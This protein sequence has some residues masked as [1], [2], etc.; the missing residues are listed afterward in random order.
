MASGSV[1]LYCNL[2]GHLWRRLDPELD[3][4]SLILAS[5]AAG[6]KP[7]EE[8]RPPNGIPRASR[9][10]VR[11]PMRYRT[12]GDL[13]WRN[14]VTENISRSGILF[15]P[16]RAIEPKMPVDMILVLPGVVAGEPPSRLRCQG[17]IV[18]TEV[19]ASDTAPSAAAAVA[20]YRLTVS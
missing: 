9:F 20:D 11:L 19:D 18:R 8:A 7:I 10:I 12:A 15:R 1:W 17:E 16:E 3:A 2:C 5:R 4:F 6:A 14:G 13:D